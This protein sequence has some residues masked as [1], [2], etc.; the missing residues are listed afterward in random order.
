M[1]GRIFV[2]GMGIISGIGNN[3]EENLTSLLQSRSGI[4]KVQ[5]IQGSNIGDI[6]VSEVKLS[7]SDLFKLAGIAERE[8]YS[9]N[10]LLGIVAARVL[11][12]WE[13]CNELPPVCVVIVNNR[14]SIVKEEQ[15]QC[16]SGFVLKTDE[17]KPGLYYWKIIVEGDL[18]FT[19]KLTIL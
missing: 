14:G 12:S 4:G 13:S 6:P 18:L 3:L 8:G 19:G 7:N 5:Y 10:S 15:V 1:P 2:T 17:Y 9:R 16:A 11:F